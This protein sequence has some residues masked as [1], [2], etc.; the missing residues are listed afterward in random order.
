MCRA[1]HWHSV[2]PLYVEAPPTKQEMR[3]YYK[4]V[5]SKPKNTRPDHTPREFAD[6]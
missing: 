2:Q 4:S 3:E 1:G 6:V 5:R